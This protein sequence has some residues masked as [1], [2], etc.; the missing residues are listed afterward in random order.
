MYFFSFPFK[1]N[2]N[3]EIMTMACYLDS[4]DGKVVYNYVPTQEN[5]AS[6]ML[7]YCIARVSLVPPML[8]YYFLQE[9]SSAA[10]II[11]KYTWLAPL[12]Y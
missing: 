6:D 3:S 4:W 12:K 10:H 1:L 5:N 9:Y 7:G 11:N 2:L 8:H